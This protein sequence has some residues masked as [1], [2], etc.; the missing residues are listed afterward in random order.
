MLCTAVCEDLPGPLLH[1][2]HVYGASAACQA[3]PFSF[4]KCFFLHLSD[5]PSKVRDQM[6]SGGRD[7]RP[8]G[9]CSGPGG[10]LARVRVGEE[11]LLKKRSVFWKQGRAFQEPQMEHFLELMMGIGQS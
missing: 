9:P 5:E 1:S 8:L 6:V 2:T 7:G 11:L 3:Q 4:T 10:E